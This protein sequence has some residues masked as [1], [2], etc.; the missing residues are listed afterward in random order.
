MNKKITIITATYNSGHALKQC[1]DSV[2]NQTYKN[3]EYIIIDNCSTDQTLDIVRTYEEKIS[4]IISEPDKGIFDALNKGIKIA[5]GDVIGFLHADDFYANN[6]VLEKI[7]NL[8]DDSGA[9]SVYGD[10]QYVSKLN[11]DKVIRN[12]VA[13]QFSIQKLKKG[14]MPP[15]PSFFVR[16]KVYSEN[17]YFNLKYS[18]SADYD[19][20]LRLFYGARIS[21]A[22][23][24]EV[25][26]KMRVGGTS[27]R[28]IGN[29]IKK[30]TEDL[31]AIRK[32]RVGGFHT[33]FLKNIRKIDQFFK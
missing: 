16:K 22:Y 30:S 33:L 6:F 25:V 26:V 3:I 28:S 5:T 24:P 11:P 4:K 2:L 19:I 1:I 32:N 15:H 10:L 9:D 29:I 17:G 18:I 13:G 14:W 31:K 7:M 21:T 12:W 23:L 20:I 27:N 8:F